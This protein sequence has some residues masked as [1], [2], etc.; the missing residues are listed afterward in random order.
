MFRRWR[1][2]T[3]TRVD[4]GAFVRSHTLVYA[5]R[6]VLAGK[7][8]AVSQH[9]SLQSSRSAQRFDYRRAFQ[10]HDAREMKVMK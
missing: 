9:L 2:F 8:D 7:N 4:L 3:S 1:V 10:S 6:N 5:W